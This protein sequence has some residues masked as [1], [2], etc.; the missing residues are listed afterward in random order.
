VAQ[1]RDMTCTRGCGY[2]FMYSW[3]RVQWTLETCRLI[4]Q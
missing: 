1:I 2:S 4:L 3:R